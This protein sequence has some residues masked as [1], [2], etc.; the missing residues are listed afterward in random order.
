MGLN[1]Y[2]SVE[3]KLL[4]QPSP[5]WKLLVDGACWIL[6]ARFP[7]YLGLP[8]LHPDFSIAVTSLFFPVSSL[9]TTSFPP[10]VSLINKTTDIENHFWMRTCSKFKSLPTASKFLFISNNRR[11]NVLSTIVE[12][13]SQ[14]IMWVIVVFREKFVTYNIPS[15]KHNYGIILLFILFN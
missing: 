11:H 7:V 1:K 8:F 15:L 9:S 14:L 12:M 4:K 5:D 6:R 13:A 2:K 10:F 3:K